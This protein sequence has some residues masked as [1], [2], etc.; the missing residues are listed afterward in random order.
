[1][2][3]YLI[4]LKLKKNWANLLWQKTVQW[5]LVTQRVGRERNNYKGM[6][7]DFWGDMFLILT[8]VSRVYT[9]V[10]SH[11]IFKNYY[12]LS[13]LALGQNRMHLSKICRGSP[14]FLPKI[15]EGRNIRVSQSLLKLVSLVF[16]ANKCVIF[17]KNS[18][19]YV[20]YKSSGMVIAT[21]TND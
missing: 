9:N 14:M 8:M 13:S 7:G 10:S 19:L 3:C 4:Y 18:Q 21:K 11:Q 16:F 20:G 12:K 17:G 15:C 2:L 5:F 6:Q 1:M